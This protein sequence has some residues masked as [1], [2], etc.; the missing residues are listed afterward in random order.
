MPRAWHRHLPQSGTS[1]LLPQVR[2]ASDANEVGAG[3]V[4]ASCEA[5]GVDDVVP[6]RRQKCGTVVAEATVNR[7][8]EPPLW[9]RLIPL[10]SEGRG[11][12]AL[13][14]AAAWQ[15][16]RRS[17]GSVERLPLLKCENRL[18]VVFGERRVARFTTGRCETRKRSRRPRDKHSGGGRS[19]RPAAHRCGNGLADAGRSRQS[20]WARPCAVPR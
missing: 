19:R 1:C 13:R 20:K 3:D 10:E 14:G 12:G 18:A 9:G 7:S 8:P 2:G 16:K 5:I 6:A 4:R 15:G 17:S 11:A